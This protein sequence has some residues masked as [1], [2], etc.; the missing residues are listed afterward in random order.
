MIL[1]GYT[2]KKTSTLL[3]DFACLYVWFY[4]IF[5]VYCGYE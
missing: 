3:G 4:D 5:F 2:L 1:L